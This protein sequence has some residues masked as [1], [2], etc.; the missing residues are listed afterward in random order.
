[1]QPKNKFIKHIHYFRAF[2]IINIV[3][4][5]IWYIP[6]KYQDYPGLM[7]INITR[8]VAFHDSAI[9]FIFVSGFLFY[10]L[11]P[12]FELIKYY[13]SKLFNVIF[14]YIFLTSLIILFDKTILIVHHEY[15]I[16][17][18]FK[19]IGWSLLHGSARI[20]YW[21]IPFIFLVFLV[22]PILLKV[23]KNIFHKVVMV[24]CLLPL[25][26][27]RTGTQISFLQYIY[28][29]PIY[30]LGIYV[31]MDYSNFILL[32]RRKKS[33]LIFISIVS[34]ILLIFLRGKSY[35]IG[36]FNI[37]ESL[38]YI[39][40][41]SICFLSIIILIK[42]EN[43]EIAWLDYFATYSFAIYFTHTL[44]GNSFI[45]SWY[46]HH[47]FSKSPG[48][49]VPLSIFFVVTI[50]FTTLLICLIIKKIL[51]KRSRYFIGA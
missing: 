25:L 35:H 16:F 39:Q 31:A 9:Y 29:F 17:D 24:G 41:I 4:V 43:K 22:S 45:M 10:Y 51:G 14:P 49:I 18:L 37:T 12:K 7:F 5:H 32:I 28:F 44:V 30:L 40:K 19:K 23:P 34:S 42:L 47:V 8:E 46:Y 6:L 50:A 33:V 48:L 11:S 21:Y 13:K 1:M 20:Q 15:T 27:T 36:W 2:A 38:Y 3:F 26:G